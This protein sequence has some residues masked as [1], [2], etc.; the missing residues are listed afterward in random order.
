M[1]IKNEDVLIFADEV[2]RDF[3]LTGETVHAVKSTTLKI[4][5]KK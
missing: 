2:S 3:K 5:K 1:N 4:I